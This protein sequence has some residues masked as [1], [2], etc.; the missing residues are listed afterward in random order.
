MKRTVVI[1]PNEIIDAFKR[2]CKSKGMFPGKVVVEMMKNYV[3][4]HR[5]NGSGKRRV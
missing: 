2:L 4:E 1:G 3:E 5:R